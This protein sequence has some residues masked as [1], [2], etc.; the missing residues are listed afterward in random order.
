MELTKELISNYI[1]SKNNAWSPATQRSERYRLQALIGVDVRNPELLFETLSTSHK[2]YTIKTIFIRLGELATW[3]GLPNIY[4]TFMERQRRTFKNVYSREIIDADYSDVTARINLIEDED[5]KK[6][7]SIL[8]TSGLRAHE[9]QTV[10]G[11]RV[12][13]KGLKE[14]PYFGL[15]D[16][17]KVSYSR[18]YRGL[19]Q[20]G[21]KPHSLRKLFASRLAQA[22]LKPEDLCKIMGWSS[23]ETAKWY[24]Q[25]KNN[26]ELALAIQKAIA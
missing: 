24:L 19:R 2:P 23:F 25:P 22:G 18:L 9:L 7:S 15:Q 10:E 5:V 21:L 13:G 20:V 12:L 17:P 14:R 6:A 16:I 26:S 3:Q 11:A 1:D 8:L 4:K